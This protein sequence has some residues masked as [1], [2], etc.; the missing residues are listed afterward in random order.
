MVVGTDFGCDLFGL[1]VESDEETWCNNWFSLWVRG[2]S[3]ATL[4]A[5]GGG[6]GRNMELIVLFGHLNRSDRNR[7]F[8][9]F[10]RDY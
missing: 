2:I 1:G 7:E 8:K 9:Y 3:R 6:R 5:H 4:V 10:A